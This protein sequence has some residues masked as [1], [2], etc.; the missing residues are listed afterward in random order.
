MEEIRY[1]AEPKFC[2]LFDWLI[3][4]AYERPEACSVAKLLGYAYQAAYRMDRLA[5]S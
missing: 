3:D 5:C 4:A 1:A 2:W